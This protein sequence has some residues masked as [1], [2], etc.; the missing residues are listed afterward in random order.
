MGLHK[1]SREAQSAAHLKVS[2]TKA[3]RS[4]RREEAG[5]KRAQ[6]KACVTGRGKR[7]PY[8]V[9]KH[10]AGQWPAVLEA[11]SRRSTRDARD[12]SR[13]RIG[14]QKACFVPIESI[15][16]DKKHRDAEIADAK[17]ASHCARSE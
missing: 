1:Q 13:K 4:Q 9:G 16:P 6:A 15:G 10:S 8:E 5:Q 2:P 12:A 17:N 7:R 11:A 14:T 3:E